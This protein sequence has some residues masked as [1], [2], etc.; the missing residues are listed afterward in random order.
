M[1]TVF[2][3]YIPVGIVKGGAISTTEFASLL[4]RLSQ[5]EVA[6]KTTVLAIGLV[7]L[8]EEQQNKAIIQQ[9]RTFY[10]QGLR[11]LGVAIQDADRRRSEVLLVVPQLLGL[12]EVSLS[13]I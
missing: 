4:P 11:E 2:N 13:E 9:G 5:R 10:G 3:M 7:T 8:G 6:L 1:E 12:Y